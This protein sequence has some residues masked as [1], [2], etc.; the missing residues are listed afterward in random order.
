MAKKNEIGSYILLEIPVSQL[1]LD[2]L[3]GRKRL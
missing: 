1:H 2:G 3:K